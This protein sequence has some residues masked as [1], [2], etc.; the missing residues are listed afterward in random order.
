MNFYFFSYTVQVKRVQTKELNVIYKNAVTSQHPINI[1][2]YFFTKNTKDKVRVLLSW[3]EISKQDYENFF[4]GRRV[5][6]LQDIE[7]H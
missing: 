3:Q 7:K 6:K 5:E 1:Q 2:N 4:A